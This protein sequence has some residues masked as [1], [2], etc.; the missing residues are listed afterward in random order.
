MFTTLFTRISVICSQVQTLS[1][2]SVSEM[3][4]NVIFAVLNSENKA[5]KIFRSIRD[6]NP[7]PPR[8]QCINIVLLMF[9]TRQNTMTCICLFP[10]STQMIQVYDLERWD[11]SSCSPE[12]CRYTRARQE[13][14]TSYNFEVCQDRFQKTM[15]LLRLHS[16]TFQER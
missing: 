6:L 9:G 10:L 12:V 2:V 4:L 7:W 8:F 3:N 11:D 16:F 13:R 14:G 5:W 15:I 1:I